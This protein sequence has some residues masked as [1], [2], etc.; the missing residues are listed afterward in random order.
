MKRVRLNFAIRVNGK[1]RKANA[2]VNLTDADYRALRHRQR[3]GRLLFEDASNPRPQPAQ[4]E[5]EATEDDDPPPD[6]DD[7]GE[8]E[9]E[10]TESEDE[11]TPKPKARARRK[12]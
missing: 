10:E 7:D 9:G 8:D 5:P 12:T 4:V 2:I 6:K 11:P 1:P 3:G